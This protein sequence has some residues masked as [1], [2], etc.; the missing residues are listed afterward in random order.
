M[1]RLEFICLFNRHCFG[2][3]K[4]LASWHCCHIVWVVLHSL[5]RSLFWKW[6]IVALYWITLQW[7]RYPPNLCTDNPYYLLLQCI[8][9][10]KTQ[11]SDRTHLWDLRWENLA[12]CEAR[13]GNICIISV[14]S[15]Q[16]R[17]ESAWSV[18]VAAR[19]IAWPEWRRR[20]LPVGWSATLAPAEFTPLRNVV[21]AGAE[22]IVCWVTF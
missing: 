11:V 15:I 9:S 6:A 14:H 18:G 20:R 16:R 5:T 17:A 22:K 13:W 2:L 19:V 3:F 10:G 12:R 4:S 1:A 7:N 8:L 21:G